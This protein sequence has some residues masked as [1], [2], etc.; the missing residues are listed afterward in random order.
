MSKSP[1]LRRIQA[2]IRELALEPSPE[3]HA[4]PL[5]S[6]MFEWHFTIRGP[7]STA[8]DGGVYHGR[9]LLPP[10]YPFKPPHIILLT[11]SGRFAT[12]TKV[13]L[14]FSAYHP[15]LWQPAWGI[16][17]I[18]EA[19]I[20][21]LDTPAD[22]AIGA[23]D[24]SET[25]RKRLAQ[26]SQT[27]ACPHCGMVANLLPRV[28]PC[29]VTT[30]NSTTNNKN[31]NKK[32]S[33]FAK[34]IQELQRLQ[35]QEHNKKEEEDGNDKKDDGN[36]KKDDGNDGT[37]QQQDP[38]VPT[39][40]ADATTDESPATT[41]RD[42]EA[43]TKVEEEQLHPTP[44]HHSHNADTDHDSNTPDDG[45]DATGR[46]APMVVEPPAMPMQQ[47][48]P[49]Q[50]QQRGQPQVQPPQQP[51]SSSSSSSSSSGLGWLVDPLLHLMIAVLSAI[52][53]LLLRKIQA[54]AADLR[55]L[56]EA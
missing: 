8:F 36:D 15:E 32:S 22:G 41:P 37:D 12:N 55:A 53:L 35:L 9:I 46:A 6:D 52:C 17:L 54:L 50:Q 27:W 13:C 56:E 39:T 10:E 40:E 4:A 45:D 5:E 18:L 29:L 51:Q 44:T 2:D 16:R 33:R 24:W 48:Q 21:F 23:L 20:S 3:Y 38:T 31:G 11:P 49:L 28:D 1:S 7:P 25:E 47:V 42:K 34:E 14:S 30:T 26:A 19:L 43:A